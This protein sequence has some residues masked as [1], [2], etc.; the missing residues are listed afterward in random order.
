MARA[1]G[2]GPS[3][4]DLAAALD[5][6]VSTISRALSNAPGISDEVRQR[7][8]QAAAQLGYRSRGAAPRQDFERI[9]VVATIFELNGML[10]WVYQEM[11]QSIIASARQLAI[12]LECHMTVETNRLPADLDAHLDP[13]V[14][15]IFLG[16]VP[17]AP[18]IDW[19]GERDIAAIIVNGVD[20]TLQMDS[21]SPANYFG[22]RLVGEYLAS[23][24]HRKIAFVGGSARWT[25]I[26]RFHGLRDGLAD[27]WGNPDSIVDSLHLPADTTQAHMNKLREWL[28]ECL[29][30]ATALFCFNDSIAV[31]V[32]QSINSLGKSVPRDVSVVGFDDMPVAGMTTPKLTTF[33]IDWQAIGS[34]A[35][36][37]LRHRRT[38]G[39]G[40]ALELQVGGK[41]IERQSA[42]GRN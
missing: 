1:K 8:S 11:L 26:R 22:G 18:T 14:G 4:A 24:G 7:V 42:I 38:V 30:K 6:S 35:L 5:L 21:I 12:P 27:H 17:D 37:Q 40:A 33:R 36:R 23:L 39:R 16:L 19:L 29:N 13:S 32:I 31:T 25:L 41:L 34:D 15:L 9:V 10:S 3:Q 20:P 2:T 28:P